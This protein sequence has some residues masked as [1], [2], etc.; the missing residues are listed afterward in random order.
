MPQRE[1]IGSLL[2]VKIIPTNWGTILA[3]RVFLISLRIVPERP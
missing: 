2:T 3:V 1:R